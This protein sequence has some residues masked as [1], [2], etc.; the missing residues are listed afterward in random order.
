MISFEPVRGMKDYFGEDAQKLEFIIDVFRKTV[1]NA[2]YSEI[3]TPILED[4]RLFSLK[5]GEELRNTMYVF[6]DKGGR[7]L[8]LRPE[9]TPSVVRA[10]LNNFQHYPKPIRLYYV[11]TVYRYDEPQFGRYREFRQAGIEMLGENTLNSD[12]EVIH[13]LYSFYKNLNLN[14][15]SIKL[16]NIGIYRILFNYLKIPDE[17][18]EHIL[19]LIDKNQNSEALK[20][21]SLYNN[22]YTNIFHA[23]LEK[24][25]WTEKE[26]A[27]FYSDYLEKININTINL[28]YQ[29]LFDIFDILKS[30]NANVYLDLSFVRGLAYYTGI[31]FEVTSKSLPFSIAGGGR[32]DNLV[33]LYGGPSTPAIGFAVGIER[34]LEALKSIDKKIESRKK[35]VVIPLDKSVIDYSIKITESIRS[36]N[37]EC[38]F[39][40]KDIPLSKLIPFYV[41]QGYNIAIII[42]KKEKQSKNVTIRYLDSK[43]QESISEDSLVE[44]LRQII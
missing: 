31:I 27:E 16:N 5:G 17:I 30:I 25:Q 2:G 44:R 26:L 14:T 4:F 22:N 21:I 36:N 19:H 15:I 6:T 20:I 33:E 8:A 39:N 10:F 7:E 9:F 42:G 40:T 12:V 34:T 13:L 41:E 35:I 18:Q 37:I 1:E 28:E 32:Y 3:I 29:R 24:K 38:V 23:M 11:G 43:A